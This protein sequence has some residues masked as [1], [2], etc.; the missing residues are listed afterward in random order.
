MSI[1]ANNETICALATPPGT[2]A[3]ALVRISGPDAISIADKVIKY[4]DEKKLSTQHS[5]TVHYGSAM[6]KEN[7]LDEVMAAVYKAPHSYTGE[8]TVEISCHG[9]FY[10]QNRLLQVLIK[11][12]ARL[13]KPGE[14]TMRA[15]LNGKMDLSRAEAVADLIASGTKS[16]HEA[17]IQQMRGGFAK[18]IQNL[19]EKLVD[20]ASLI[21]LELDFSEED[22]EFASRH[23]L[24]KLLIE[25]KNALQKLAGS[26]AVG[27]VIKNGV[28]VVIAG[29]PNAGKSTLLNALLNEERAIVSEEP[30]TTRDFI[31]DTITINGIL[32]RFIDTAGIRKPSDKIESIGI[33]RTYEKM[34][35][36]SVILYLFDA[37]KVNADEVNAVLKGIKTKEKDKVLPVI[38]KTD[39]L[40]IKE[41][42]IKFATVKNAVFISA[43]KK[44]GINILTEKLFILSGLQNWD[45]NSVTVTNT[46]HYEA[47]SKALECIQNTL[48]GIKNRIS[49]DL[50]ATD[51]RMALHHLGEITGEVTN[52]EI[53]ENIFG[54]FCIG[55]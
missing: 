42:G 46:R 33:A 7:L 30:G 16:M 49:A 17:A 23:E 22:V 25:I 11:A 1:T 51:I 21:E 39:L 18:E 45:S 54:K 40:N 26:F 34:E 29:A 14:F 55:K 4:K 20:F 8:D 48:R 38:N 28:G 32:F 43:R 47:L 5:H 50:L 27:N 2:S 36:A 31:E 6:D 53:L 19:R 52:D 13:A 37:L 44:E 24:Q 9:S 35:Q 15:F 10:I 12:G 3:I 41:A